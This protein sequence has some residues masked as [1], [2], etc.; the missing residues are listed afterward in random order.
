MIKRNVEQLCGKTLSHLADDGDYAGVIHKD[1][2]EPLRELQQQASREGFDLR[3]VSGFRSFERQLKI[4]NS[5]AGGDRDVLDNECQ[6]IDISCLSELELTYA[7]LRWSALPG[8]SR[9]HWGTDFDV[10]DAAAISQ[11]Y[12]IQLVPEETEGNGPFAA[13]HRWL[14]EILPATDFY[15]PYEK[16]RGGVAPE[17]WHLSYRPLAD[18]FAGQLSPSAVLYALKQGDLLVGERVEVALNDCI[19]KNIDDIYQRFISV[20]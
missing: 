17:P 12:E 13:M 18:K 2:V 7:I 14:D 5:K 6:A 1:V 16:D 10:Y 8:A 9:H 3:V 19:V 11:D 4:W 15:R 20:A